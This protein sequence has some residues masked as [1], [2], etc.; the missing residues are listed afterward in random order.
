M[1]NAEGV[2]VS[3][4]ICPVCSTGFSEDDEIVQCEHCKIC[5]HSDCWHENR[6]CATYGC[7]GAS[8]VT[9][10]TTTADIGDADMVTCQC[11]YV[12]PAT[13]LVCMS[14]GRLVDDSGTD[15]GGSMDMGSAANELKKVG[16]TFLL[17]LKFILGWV[18]TTLSYLG[19]MYAKYVQ[20]TGE[21]KR[22]TFWPVTIVVTF[23][24]YMSYMI[25]DDGDL[26]IMY[27]LAS[28]CPYIT[29]IARRFR[30]VG[31]S[32]WY[33]IFF[34]IAV[35]VWFLTDWEPLGLVAFVPV[36]ILLLA[37]TRQEMKKGND[38]E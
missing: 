21:E 15:G 14:C 35:L 6:G 34:P 32:P 3:D 7:S 16:E 27:S 20:V 38:H 33:C 4:L 19:S 12:H 23:F 30:D 37:P 8:H 36:G 18:A 17:S 25:D 1:E 9:T 26:L 10:H 24:A 5:Y 2:D 28:C 22:K 31:L 11:G 13:D 29:M